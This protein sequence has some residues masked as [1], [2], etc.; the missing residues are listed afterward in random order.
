[1]LDFILFN[2]III[3]T[4]YVMYA[5]VKCAREEKIEKNRERNK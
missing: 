1:M 3:F 5:T 4:A 2:V